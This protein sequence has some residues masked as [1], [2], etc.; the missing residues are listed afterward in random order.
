MKYVFE[1]LFGVPRAQLVDRAYRIGEVV[2]RLGETSISAFLL[3][4]LIFAEDRRFLRHR[5]FDKIAIVRSIVSW[6]LRGKRQGGSTIEQQLVRTITNDRV[7]SIRRKLREIYCANV[8]SKRFRKVQ[9][10]RCYLRCAYLGWE[11][12]GV[13]PAAQMLRM[14]ISSLTARQASELVARIRY[15]TPHHIDDARAVLTRNRAEYILRNISRSE[16]MKYDE[17]FASPY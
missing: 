12:H 16:V 2:S 6:A 14:R 11:R 7:Y 3:E 15:P 5:G 9:L 8:I 13:E 1:V 17:D 10:A 4:A